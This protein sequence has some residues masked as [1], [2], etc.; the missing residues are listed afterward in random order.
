MKK[1]VAAR[2]FP[3]ALPA[4][5]VTLFLVLFFLLLPVFQPPASAESSDLGDAGAD[6]TVYVTAT[7]I[8]YHREG[9]RSLSR[10]KIALSLADA[11][12]SGYEPCGICNPP[13]SAALPVSPRTAVLYQVNIAGL[14]SV[15][16]ADLSRMTGA[17]VVGH[18]DGDTVRVRIKNPPAGLDAVETIRMIGVDTPETVHPR[19]EVEFFGK[20]ASEFT[21]QRLLGQ[22][23]FLAFDWDRRDRYGRLLAYIYSPDGDC[24]NAA[25]IREGYAHAYTSFSF[26]FMD[27][28]R[29]LEQEA[30]REKRG[31]WR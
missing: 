23:V 19:R 31:L 22:P 12:G 29:S 6:S 2:R 13:V 9:C 30:R 5:C 10:S 24:H 21:R 1:E 8:K 17:E 27:E 28:F 15:S 20:E 25:L 14:R 18:V 7:G 11:A 26:Q 16:N 3:A 4:L